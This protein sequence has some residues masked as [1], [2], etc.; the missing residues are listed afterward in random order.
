MLKFCHL[1]IMSGAVDARKWSA[2]WRNWNICDIFISLNST[3]G[4]K[5]QRQPETFAPCMGTVPSETVRQENGFILLR[6]I[7]LTLVTLQVQ[8]DLQSLMK[9]V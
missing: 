4:R 7:F 1:K 2:K 3:E 5:Q 9:I 6:R 8:E